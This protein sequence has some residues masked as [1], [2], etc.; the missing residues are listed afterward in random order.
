[1]GVIMV[2][3]L[4]K[5]AMDYEKRYNFP[6]TQLIKDQLSAVDHAII[7]G[8]RERIRQ[9]LQ[10]AFTLLTPYIATGKKQMK[11]RI[12]GITDIYKREEFIEEAQQLR[13]A[14]FLLM[15]EKTG[16]M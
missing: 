11:D 7:T 1:M 13:P 15:E 10:C 14:L 16:V 9:S 6:Y 3:D 2:T 8:D 4:E 5:K 12:S